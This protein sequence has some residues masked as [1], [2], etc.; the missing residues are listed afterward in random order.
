MSFEIAGRI[1]KI[2]QERDLNQ[3]TLAKK[4]EISRTYLSQIESGAATNVS[5]A[6]LQR[7]ALAL[8]VKPSFL[9]GEDSS[10]PYIDSSLVEYAMDYELDF[11]D[12]VQLDKLA[13]RGDRP[14]TKEEWKQLHD[15]VKEVL[16]KI[17]NNK[18]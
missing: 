3:E 13:F 10:K 2:R 14:K 12:L 1:K 5:A 18:K 9:L 17:E 15:A 8:E 6:V 7:I 4:A 16:E 11:S